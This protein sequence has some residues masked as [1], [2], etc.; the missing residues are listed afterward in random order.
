MANLQPFGIDQTTGQ[1]RQTITADIA[2]NSAVVAVE[3]GE[4]ITITDLQSV[5]T[6]LID[7]PGSFFTLNTVDTFMVN[8]HITSQS[9]TVGPDLKLDLY[10]NA[11]VIV[12]RSRVRILTKVAGFGETVQLTCFVN[13]TVPNT[14]YKLRGQTGSGSH[15][16]SNNAIANGLSTITWVQTPKALQGF[17]R[18]LANPGGSSYT[19]AQLQALYD[20][21]PG[22]NA[23]DVVPQ[24]IIDQANILNTTGYKVYLGHNSWWYTNTATGATVENWSQFGGA[25]S[26]FGAAIVANGIFTFK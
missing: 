25:K 26:N 23:P 1:Y 3:S 2:I 10:T 16:M 4:C 14:T 11:N 5:S 12:P 24:A 22:L 7:I 13:N 18:L 9:G 6:T 20:G 8:I 21:I 15:T 17:L 19:Q